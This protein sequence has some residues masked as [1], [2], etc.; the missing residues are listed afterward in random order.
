ME[1]DTIQT[2]ASTYGDGWGIYLVSVLVLVALY[3]VQK[4]AYLI[5]RWLNRYSNTKPSWEG[6][7][8]PLFLAILLG[9]FTLLYNVFSPDDMQLNPLYWHWPEW[10]LAG[11][12]MVGIAMVAVESFKHFDTKPGLFRLVIFGLLMLGFFIAGLLAGLLIVALL[13]LWML[14]YFIGRWRKT[15]V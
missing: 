6:K 15:M 9:V 14:I 2:N 1:T 13:A 10:L 12:F 5:D 3:F 4:H 7:P 11:S 8:W